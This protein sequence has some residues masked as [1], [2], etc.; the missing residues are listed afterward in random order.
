MNA[1]RTVTIAG[2][3]ALGTAAAASASTVTLDYTGPT[4]GAFT[5]INI[6]ATPA[7]STGN[8]LAGAFNFDRIA[9]G[10]VVGQIIAWCMDLSA[11]LNQGTRPYHEGGSFIGG[12][13]EI[14]GAGDRVQQLFDAVFHLIN[15]ADQ[16]QSAAM[17][18]A[19]W[20]T[21]YDT[22]WTLSTG[23]FRVSGPGGVVT[24]AQEL[25]SLAADYTGGQRWR[26][27]YFD[28]AAVDG[29]D[30][31]Q[32]VGTASPIPLPAAGWLLLAGLGTLGAVAR[33]RRAA[34]A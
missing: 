13:G 12:V 1:F 28:A 30:K 24:Q 32:N 2:A 3:L 22:D 5:T 20:E 8:T 18:T 10:S 7:G 21:I 29:L 17:Q 27:T 16:A 33:R 31:Q 34:T 14:A 25:L 4:A 6:T 11:F 15:P 9:E 26:M 19:I 23:S